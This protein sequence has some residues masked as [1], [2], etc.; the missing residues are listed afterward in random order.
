MIYRS[1]FECAF[2]LKVVE[3]LKQGG[4]AADKGGPPRTRAQTKHK[5]DGEHVT[6]GQWQSTHRHTGLK[7]MHV[8]AR[9]WDQWRTAVLMN[10][11]GIKSR[12]QIST[13]GD[14]VS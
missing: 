9:G 4:Q 12:K 11:A 6:G 13:Q 7:M 14:T 3:L 5:Q 10:L 2:W 1:D 8:I